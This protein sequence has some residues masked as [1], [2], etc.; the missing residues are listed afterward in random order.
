MMK[1]KDKNKHKDDGKS[2]DSEVTYRLF[3]RVER[4]PSGE[5]EVSKNLLQCL[6]NQ[7]VQ[8]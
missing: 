4:S 7:L 5:C 3:A 2:K 6:R 8:Q 1:G